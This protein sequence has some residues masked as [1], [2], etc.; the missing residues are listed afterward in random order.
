[1]QSREMLKMALQM[2]DAI[3]LPV[4]DDMRDAPLAFPTPNG[5]NHPLWIVGHLAFTEGMIL[6]T[7]MRGDPNP[8]AEWA[9][10]F[11]PGS[12][13]AADA[14][15]Y[16]PYDK[17]IERYRSMREQSLAFLDSLS[18]EDL[19]QPSRQSPPG[20]DMLFGTYRHCYMLT[21]LHIANH[22]GQMLD[23]RRAAGRKPLF[24]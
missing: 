12:E 23:A 19:D 7:I 20:F 11:G 4:V 14:D 13:P 3:L 24:R 21:A 10:L 15:R 18:E 5:G 2:S 9:E 22:R 17:L 16:P 6:W 1:M 8:L